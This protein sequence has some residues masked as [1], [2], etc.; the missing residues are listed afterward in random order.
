MSSQGIE[1][2][3][4]QILAEALN[5]HLTIMN[6]S[7]GRKWGQPMENGT[8]T[9]MTGDLTQRRAHMAVA[10]YFIHIHI[11]EVVDMTV[12]YDMEFGC[13]ITPLPEPLPQWVA[14]IYPF[15]LPVI[16]QP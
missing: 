16:A 10:N 12:A 14:L 2:R 4:L 3:L 13:F 5:F 8:W 7:D 11:L 6:P 9:G 1:I 15:S